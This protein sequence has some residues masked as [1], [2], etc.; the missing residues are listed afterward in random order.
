M[1]TQPVTVQEIFEA[2]HEFLKKH[3]IF[4][5]CGFEETYSAKNPD[6]VIV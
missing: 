1:T 4:G 3:S 5:P 6:K 2:E